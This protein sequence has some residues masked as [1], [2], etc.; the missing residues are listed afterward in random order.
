MIAERNPD[1]LLSAVESR[2]IFPPVRLY[3]DYGLEVMT[4]VNERRR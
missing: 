4:F 1:E 3:C 2:K